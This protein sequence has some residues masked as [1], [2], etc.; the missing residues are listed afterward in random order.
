MPRAWARREALPVWLVLL[1]GVTTVFDAWRWLPVVHPDWLIARSA[2]AALLSRQ[3]LSVYELF[4]RAQMGPLALLLAQ[5][6]RPVYVVLSAAAVAPCLYWLVAT[7]LSTSQRWPGRSLLLLAVGG[8]LVVAPWAQL[9][10][11]GHADDAL[12]LL[13][14]AFLIHSTARGRRWG[15]LLGLAVALGG[16]PTALAVVPILLTSP[17]DTLAA[18]LVV[19]AIWGPFF[20]VDAMAMMRAGKG[21]MTV[22]HGS[23]PAY[24]G[25]G[26]GSAP[27]VWIRTSQLL[28][29]LGS[30]ALGV[31]RRNPVEG[32]LLGFAVRALIDPNPAPA[33][34]IPLVVLALAVDLRRGWPLTLPLAALS[35]SLSQPVLNGGTGVFRLAA[36][37]ALIVT[38]A[39]LCVAVPGRGAPDA[40]APCRR[41]GSDHEPET[42][43]P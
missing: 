33:Y 20:A 32:L 14:A 40:D 42:P 2:G 19:G 27:A 39:V 8:I 12:V 34:S 7:S 26:V 18:V 3:G 25:A 38:A 4:P 30:S 24:L 22:G 43:P 36:L 11:K 16:K 29:G 37:A 13:G 6:P 31:V 15:Q 5:L 10:W 23:L 1:V 35:F 21:V 17:V 28:G 41:V 9:A